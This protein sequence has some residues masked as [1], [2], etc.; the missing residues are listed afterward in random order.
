MDRAIVQ[1]LDL[2]TARRLEH[3]RCREL[4][5][6]R[7]PVEESVPHVRELSLPWH[8]RWGISSVAVAQYGLVQACSRFVVCVLV[9]EDDISE[10]FYRL[11]QLL[12]ALIPFGG[13]LVQKDDA[14][15][16]EA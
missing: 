10:A 9:V 3:R 12:V 13:V 7:Q 14:L 11:E 4:S 6:V 1:R 16:D 5:A 8:P 2:E 15:M